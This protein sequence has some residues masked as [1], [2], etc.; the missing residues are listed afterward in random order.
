MMNFIILLFGQKLD[1]LFKLMIFV[2][3]RLKIIS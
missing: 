1:N 3:N 2:D